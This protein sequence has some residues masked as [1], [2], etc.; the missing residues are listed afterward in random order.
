MNSFP[1]KQVKSPQANTDHG[2]PAP[3]EEGP[4]Q[5]LNS[6]ILLVLSIVKSTLLVIENCTTLSPGLSI[7]HNFIQAK[8][9]LSTPIANNC[10]SKHRFHIHSAVLI[11]TVLTPVPPITSS[12]R[13]ATTERTRLHQHFLLNLLQMKPLHRFHSVDRRVLEL[14]YICRDPNRNKE[15]L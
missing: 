1:V 5:T 3:D 15:S 11:F 8:I 10:N 7:G 9:Q 13:F 4:M 14:V 6:K 12:N 2:E